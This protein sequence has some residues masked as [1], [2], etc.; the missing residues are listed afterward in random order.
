MDVTAFL[1]DMR[2][3]HWYEG[4]AIH[5]EDIPV[6]PARYSELASPLAR[7]L[8]E[9]L[10]AAGIARLYSHQ[11]EA[12]DAIRGGENVIVATPAASGKS[13]CYHLPVLDTLLTDR[14]A[15]ALFLFPTK[16]LAQD[17]STALAKLLPERGR[18]RHSSDAL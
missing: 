3:R 14:S 4:Q 18:L 9:S 13:L 7:P 1:R 17:Q 6:R 2:A 11:A 16:A 12:V 10:E 5:R 15:T 8:E